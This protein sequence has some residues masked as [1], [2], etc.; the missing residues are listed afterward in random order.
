[1]SRKYIAI[2]N[3]PGTCQESISHLF[4]SF[5][6]II[7]PKYAIKTLSPEDL[8]TGDW[9]VQTALFVLPGGAD[10]F[11]VKSLTPKGNRI[12]RQFVHEGGSFLG[13][14]AGAYY[15]GQEVQFAIGSTIEV[16]GPRDL[17]FFPGVVS[18]PHLRAYEYGTKKGACGARLLSPLLDTTLTVF[19]NGGGQFADAETF[20]EIE[21]LATYE[22]LK[23]AIIKRTYG[24]GTAILSGVHPEYD[25]E[26]M[27]GS[28]EYV[29][30]FIEELK[31]SEQ[32]RILFLRELLS[33]LNLEESTNEYT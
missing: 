13:I 31:A 10:L 1:M 9:T 15:A 30:P 14:C 33:L 5:K 28:D 22:D 18:G 7:S 24:K 25:P 16:Q 21:I 29:K 2:Y 32:N 23:P 19:Y 8:L 4:H 12:I 26:Q 6:K 11:Y 20:S 3:G 17:G 27:D